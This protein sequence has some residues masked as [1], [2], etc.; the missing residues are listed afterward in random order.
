MKIV[1]VAEYAS[2][3]VATYLR[4]IIAYQLEDETVDEVVLIN[5]NKKSEK[6]DFSSNKFKH[7]T[8]DY[9]RSLSG[10]IQLLRLRK[11]IDS[12]SPNVVHYHSSFAGA[13]RLTY[14]FRS[15]PYKVIYCAHGW[16]FSQQ[17]KS[18]FQKKYMRLLKELLHIERIP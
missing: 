5:S 3:G 8:F 2:G 18:K 10:M 14:L 11:L 6:I 15:A 16:S 17:D 1:H 7:I 12:F 13:I 9:N 4:N